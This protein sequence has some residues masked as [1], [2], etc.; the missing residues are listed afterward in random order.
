MTETGHLKI[1][2]FYRIIL[3]SGKKLIERSLDLIEILIISE[4]LSCY[5]N[6]LIS[7]VIHYLITH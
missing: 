1:G 5:V 4:K 2:N 6:Y 3:L 7:L